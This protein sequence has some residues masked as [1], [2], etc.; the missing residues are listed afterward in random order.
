[1]SWNFLADTAGAKVKKNTF[2]NDLMFPNPATF[3]GS[4]KLIEI[5]NFHQ[6]FMKL[7][8]VIF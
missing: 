7:N 5:Q 6:S 3:V 1:M 8:T 4:G 2:S